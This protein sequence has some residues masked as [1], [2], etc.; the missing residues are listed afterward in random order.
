MNCVYT[1]LCDHL[2]WLGKKAASEDKLD[3]ELLKILTGGVRRFTSG[4]IVPFLA[5][6]MAQRRGLALKVEHHLW[7]PLHYMAAGNVGERLVLLATG[8]NLFGLE[9]ERVGLSPA[10]YLDLGGQ[11]A[12]YAAQQNGGVCVMAV[13][14][15]RL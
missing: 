3:Y 8:F 14:F 10:V 11:H 12:Y 9:V 2:L 5:K 4:A 1:A 7:T 6:R 13:Q 15:S